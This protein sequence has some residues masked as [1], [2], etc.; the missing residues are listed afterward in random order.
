MLAAMRNRD[1]V[2][3]LLD[4]QFGAIARW[5]LT[6]MKVPASE[7]N[8]WVRRGHL[9]VAA[10]GVYR[11]AG[12][13]R[14]DEQAAMIA[15]LR[16][17][18]GSILTGPFV[19]GVLRVDGY[20]ADDPFEVLTPGPRR[21]TVPFAYRPN[22]TPT[23]VRAAYR[24]IPIVTP[25]VA[26]VDAARGVTGDE[27]ARRLRVAYDVLRWRG[28]VD[29]QRLRRRMDRLG[30]DDPGVQT[31]R[32]LIDDAD[33]ELESEGERLLSPLLDVYDPAPERQVWVTPQ[34]RVD[35]YFRALR[36]AIEY[37][38][39][40]DHGHAAGRASDT[41]RAFELA[42]A[43]IE[44]VTVQRADLDDAAAFHAW[45]DR[46]LMRRARELQVPA[47]TRN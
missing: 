41:D 22:P 11:T 45:F 37:Q 13:S 25:T 5:Q 12:A 36:L 42:E 15:A 4:Q 40:V 8:G 23:A 32:L 3:E 14:T 9:L 35:R 24:G 46:V 31:W 47:P 1:E 27:A 44:V 2:I 26:L 20:A 28:L 43:G 38:G 29:E 34:R 10:R 16:C 33:L 19:L 7:F 18:D 17:G 39:T 6:A 21:L 30:E